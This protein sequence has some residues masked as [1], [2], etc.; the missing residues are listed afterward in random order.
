M[1]NGREFKNVHLE[2][3][4]AVTEFYE[5][6][7]EIHEWAEV[8]FNEKYVPEISKDF[9]FMICLGNLIFLYKQD[10]KIL[11]IEDSLMEGGI[12]YGYK[13]LQFAGEKSPLILDMSIESLYEMGLNSFQ[14]NLLLFCSWIDIEMNADDLFLEVYDMVVE[15][16]E[17]FFEIRF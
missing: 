3:W 7:L 10:K 9:N 4:G 5:F 13:Q 6:F 12:E 17:N 16:F 1:F 11:L 15:I 8:L 14:R 2:Y